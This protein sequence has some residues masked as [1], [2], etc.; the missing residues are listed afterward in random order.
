MHDL[1]CLFQFSEIA[2]FL[3]DL[4]LS[5]FLNILCVVV[6]V[7]MVVCSLCVFYIYIYMSVCIVC[8][9]FDCVGELFVEFV[10]YLCK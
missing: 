3:T 7:I 8:F 4:F 9:M 5:L 1:T 2:V 6:S 10:C